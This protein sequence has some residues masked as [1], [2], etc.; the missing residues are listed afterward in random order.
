MLWRLDVLATRGDLK[1]GAAIL[2]PRLFRV[3]RVHRTFLAESHRLDAIC[4][5]ATGDKI[6]LGRG[7]ATL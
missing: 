6:T 4:G 7:R 1:L 5:D 2:R 3:S